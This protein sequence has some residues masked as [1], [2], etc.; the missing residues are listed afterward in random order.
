MYI[1]WALFI[2]IPYIRYSQPTHTQI[3][4]TCT[5]HPTRA[6][7]NSNK[8]L[9]ET[10]RIVARWFAVAHSTAT[11]QLSEVGCARAI[12]RA[13]S[14]AHRSIQPSGCLQLRVNEPEYCEADLLHTVG[15]PYILYRRLYTE[16]ICALCHPLFIV[17]TIHIYIHLFSWLDDLTVS[18]LSRSGTSMRPLHLSRLFSRIC[19]QDGVGILVWGRRS[20][21]TGV[22]ELTYS[23]CKR[24]SICRTLI[25]AARCWRRRVVFSFSQCTRRVNP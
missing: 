21:E 24:T 22:N 14:S 10:P 9:G 18:R 20:H 8:T 13:A 7:R 4:C 5:H 12:S 6:P 15:R 11:H 3:P 19:H 16:L 25:V 1:Q 17:Y 2:H 23:W